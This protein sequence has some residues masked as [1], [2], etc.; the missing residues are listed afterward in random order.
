MPRPKISTDSKRCRVECYLSTDERNAIETN[1]KTA[2]LPLSVFLRKSAL[3]HPVSV[4]PTGNAK[5]WSELA[6]FVSNLNQ[7]A[8]AAN[9]GQVVGIQPSDLAAMSREVQALRRGL[10]GEAEP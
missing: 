3:G 1:A 7:L 8:H 9:S 2:G 10:L 5:R 6:R 4:L